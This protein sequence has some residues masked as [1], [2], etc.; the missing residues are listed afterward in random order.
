[1]SIPR[2]A[3]A[4]CANSKHAPGCV[5]CTRYREYSTTRCASKV[6]A[7]RRSTAPST[8]SVASK[9][10]SVRRPRSFSRSS[11]N[12]S[13]RAAQPRAPRAGAPAFANGFLGVLLV[14]LLGLVFLRLGLR[15]RPQRL[16]R[17][18]RR[19]RRLLLHPFRRRRLGRRRRRPLVLVRRALRHTGLRRIRRRLD[20]PFLG[21]LRRLTCGLRNTLLLPRALL[22]R[23]RW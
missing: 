6:G 23:R 2:R 9:A 12:A 19:R 21:W 5:R 14:L 8:R 3:S 20:C 17:R 16:G 1:M 7:P 4:W 15:L 10:S 13:A 11:S 18:R 22:H